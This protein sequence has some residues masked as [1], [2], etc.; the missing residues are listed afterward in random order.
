[1]KGARVKES[2]AKGASIKGAS[3][4]GASTKGANADE[5][6]GEVNSR[7]AEHYASH[8]EQ[9]HWH[10]GQLS[11]TVATSKIAE[12]LDFLAND[13]AANFAQLTDLCAVDYPNRNPRFEVVYHL[14]SLELNR[15]I[16]VKTNVDEEE[17][18]PSVC[19][20]F[21]AALWYEREAWDMFGI[22][23]TGNPD[24]RRLL[25]DYDFEGH[26]LRKD[27]P[28]SGNVEVRYRHDRKKVVYEETK[29]SQNWRNFDF[30][31]PWEGYEPLLP[32]DEKATK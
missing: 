13:G 4:K 25:S 3:T 11:I 17:A 20:V 30:L 23:F 26:P 21:P 14:L 18:V 2:G 31:S 16:R 10:K 5:L 29:L 19:G 12:V 24:L 22:G 7:L 9:T 8:I 27:F 1:M 28:L 32:G 15:R 6:L